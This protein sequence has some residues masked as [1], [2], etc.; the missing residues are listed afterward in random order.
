MRYIDQN[1]LASFYVC[2]H[3]PNTQMLEAFK[4]ILENKNLD[5]IF[6]HAIIA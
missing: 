3:S 5:N 4:K 1:K 2:V 6:D